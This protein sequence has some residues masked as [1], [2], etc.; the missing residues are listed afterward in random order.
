[1]VGAYYFVEADS[2]YKAVEKVMKR[3]DEAL[4]AGEQVNE[5]YE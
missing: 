4:H 5:E 3:V 2:P 1:M